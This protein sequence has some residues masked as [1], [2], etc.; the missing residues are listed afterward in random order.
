[1]SKKPKTQ[2]LLD[3]YIKAASVSNNGNKKKLSRKTKHRINLLKKQKC[4]CF[5]CGKCFDIKTRRG[6]KEITLDHLLPK[7]MGG[8]LNSGNLVAA[9]ATCNAL[10]GNRMVNPIT[11]EEIK[12]EKLNLNFVSRKS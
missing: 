1:M 2:K 9:C 3:K 12:V 7:S 11:L 4:R 6:R 5:W 8:K 10:R